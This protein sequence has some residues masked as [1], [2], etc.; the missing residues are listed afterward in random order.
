MKS[1]AVNKLRYWSVDIICSKKQTVFWESSSRT[2]VS[3]MRNRL[4]RKIKYLWAYF[5]TKWKLFCLLFFKCFLRHAQFACLD[6]SGVS[7]PISWI[8][9]QWYYFQLHW[10][11]LKAETIHW[12]QLKVKNNCNLSI[13]DIDQHFHCTSKNLPFVI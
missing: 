2:T 7:K 13:K 12:F 8:Y 6:Q 11:D 9:N 3:L 10:F 1:T 4:Y 5:C